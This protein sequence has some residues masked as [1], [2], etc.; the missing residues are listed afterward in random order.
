MHSLESGWLVGRLGFSGGVGGGRFCHF[1]CA[2]SRKMN[3]KLELT[4]L[5]PNRGPRPAF[6][7]EYIRPTRA[8]ES[9]G[10]YQYPMLTMPML[11]NN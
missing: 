7:N 3:S 11:I 5:H 8:G 9:A 4:Q 1:V 6:R 10:V 2:A